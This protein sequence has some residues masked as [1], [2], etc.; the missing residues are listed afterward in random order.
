MKTLAIIAFTCG[1]SVVCLGQSSPTTTTTTTTKPA[2]GST[3]P[4]NEGSVWSLTMIKTKTGLSDE[5]F[6]QITGTVKPVYDEEKKQKLILDYK[7]LT[8]QAASPHDFDILIMVEYPN[9]AAFDHLRDKMDPVVAKVMGSQDEQRE[10]AV[11]RLDIREI[12]GTKTM[13]EITLK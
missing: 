5:Y 9:W 3:A 6:K 1:V 2:G 4:Y 8:G 11:K 12:L 10:L 7:I 13:Q